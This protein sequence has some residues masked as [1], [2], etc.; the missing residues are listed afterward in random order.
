MD[1][2]EDEPYEEPKIKT[3]MSGEPSLSFLNKEPIDVT[4]DILQNIENITNSNM[5]FFNKQNAIST[6]VERFKEYKKQRDDDTI[7]YF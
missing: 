5:D 6:Q 2:L 1:G 7:T 4:D 3:V